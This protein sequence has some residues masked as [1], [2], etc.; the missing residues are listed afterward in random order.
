MNKY[1]SLLS[2]LGVV[3]VLLVTSLLLVRENVNPK[4]FYKDSQSENATLAPVTYT[5]FLVPYALGLNLKGNLNRF[6]S[7]SVSSPKSHISKYDFLFHS[8]YKKEMES[9]VLNQVNDLRGRNVRVVDFI[10]TDDPVYIGSE[11]GYS[12][13]W[14]FYVGGYFAYQGL[15]SKKT[16]I[17]KKVYL[18]VKISDDSSNAKNPLGVAISEINGL[19]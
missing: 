10:V 4:V 19:P 1:T 15:F 17:T 11:I 13:S 2:L 5:P 14:A 18:F 3:I 8:D 7:F 6:L 12:R 9:Y 16:G